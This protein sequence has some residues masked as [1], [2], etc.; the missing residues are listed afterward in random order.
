MKNTVSIFLLFL[1]VSCGKETLTQNLILEENSAV[2]PYDTIAIDSFSQG[3]TTVDIAMKIKISSL[4]YQD[5]LK[6]IKLKTEEE[7]LLNKAKDEKVDA[8]KKA[9]EAEKKLE[10]S[11]QVKL[12]TPNPKADQV[13]TP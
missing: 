2:A 12:D 5:S 3:A 6:Q 11:K 7:R 9:A 10:A 8:E 4:K 13:A 1:L